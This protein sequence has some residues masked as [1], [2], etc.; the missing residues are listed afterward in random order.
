MFE[1]NLGCRDLRDFEFWGNFSIKMLK[2]KKNMKIHDLFI[3]AQ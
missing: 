1:I 2:K 3:K